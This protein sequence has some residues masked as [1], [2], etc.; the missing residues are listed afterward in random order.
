MLG[1]REPHLYGKVTLETIHR[2]CQEICD[3]HQFSL[4]FRQTNYEGELVEWVQECAE[5]GSGLVINAAAYTHTSIAVGDALSLISFPIIEVHLTNIYQRETFRHCS[6]VSPYA[7]AV[8]AG[9]G[10]KGYTLAIQSLI[11]LIC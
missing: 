5:E 4:V 6:F 11:E 8:I 10:R 2:E 7:K 9:L 3:S 1:K